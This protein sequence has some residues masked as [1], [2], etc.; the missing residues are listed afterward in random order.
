MGWNQ[1]LRLTTVGCGTHP[2]PTTGDCDSGEF[3]GWP[4]PQDGGP[5]GPL[6]C[7]GEQT[8]RMG[9]LVT[10]APCHP[11]EREQS[12]WGYEESGGQERT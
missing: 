2:A 3:L 11:S 7:I 4:W 1:L 9:A 8:R 6:G 5:Q 10:Q 12:Q